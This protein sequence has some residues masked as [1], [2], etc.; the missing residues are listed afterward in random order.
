[1]VNT[2]NIKHFSS[3]QFSSIQVYAECC[4]PSQVPSQEVSHRP[5]QKLCPHQALPPHPP[6]LGTSALLSVSSVRLVHAPGELG[7]HRV[8]G[9]ARVACGPQGSPGLQLVSEPP[10][11][12]GWTVSCDVDGPHSLLCLSPDRRWDSFRL[13]LV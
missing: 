2:C 8:P 5:K 13:S 10:S 9:G 11:L 1:M 4:V 3:I 7:S 6:V 12:G